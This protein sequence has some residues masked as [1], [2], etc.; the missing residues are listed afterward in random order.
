MIV[1]HNRKVNSNYSNI[2]H[3]H[4]GSKKEKNRSNVLNFKNGKAILQLNTDIVQ[5]K[6]RVLAKTFQILKTKIFPEFRSG[7]KFVLCKTFVAWNVIVI[8][9]SDPSSN[10][11]PEHSTWNAE[12][13]LCEIG[14]FYFYI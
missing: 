6:L 4:T 1:Y 8:I 12:K 9:Y 14:K 3:Y 11:C 10:W 5:V 2:M 7:V 13:N